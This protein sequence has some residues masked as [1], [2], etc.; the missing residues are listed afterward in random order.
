MILGRQRLGPKMQLIHIG[1]PK[2]AST[3]LQQFLFDNSAFGFRSPHG[4]QCTRLLHDLRVVDTFEFDTQIDSIRKNYAPND[5]EL[6]DVYSHE[7]LLID[8]YGERSQ[9]REGV[10]RLSKIFDS[11]KILLMIREQ[12]SAIV[13]SYNEH[14]RRGR[15]TTFDDFVNTKERELG[16]RPSVCRVYEFKYDRL[17]SYLHET[18]GTENV[19]VLPLEMTRSPDFLPRLYTFLGRPMPEAL[20]ETMSET[21]RTSRKG[22]LVFLRH[23][24]KLI[25]PSPP[26]SGSLLRRA[27]YGANILLS[28]V[29]PDTLYQAKRRKI[30]ATYEREIEGL[31]TDSNLRTSDL[32]GIDL[33]EFGYK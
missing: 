6:V 8:P 30:M 2:C 10:R 23:F 18:F 28:A 20:P 5:G 32:I 14:L 11:P 24:N 12:K 17:I 13:S 4:A 25:T 16:F 29:V 3:S 33:A 9:V 19:L 1:Y 15:T 21:T 26:H 27:L 22:D 7:H 31:Y